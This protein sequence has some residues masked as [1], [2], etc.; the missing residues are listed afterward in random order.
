[1]NKQRRFPSLSPLLP[2]PPLRAGSAPPPPAHKWPHTRRDGGRAPNYASLLTRGHGGEGTAAAWGTDRG[3]WLLPITETGEQ[4]SRATCWE[5]AQAREL[6][7]TCQPLP[8]W[9]GIA[10]R[11][12]PARLGKG[13]RKSLQ[14]PL[15]L[16]AACGG[17]ELGRGGRMTDPPGH[18]AGAGV[19]AAVGAVNGGM[20][21]PVAPGET[22]LS[23]SIFCLKTLGKS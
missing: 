19:L 9:V 11:A 20:P 15:L 14:G 1:M 12:P 7:P 3:C 16:L 23:A 21:S 17:G 8:W 13:G 2:P 5:G 4:R 18:G 10:G 6:R 22:P